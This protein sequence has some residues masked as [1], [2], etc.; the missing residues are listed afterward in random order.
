MIFALSLAALLALAGLSIDSLRVFIV[1]GQAQRAAE[2]AALAG[3]PYVPQ[4]P[5]DKTSA[6]DGN[7]ARDRALQAAAQNGFT[8]SSAITITPAAG[9]PATLTVTIH[10]NVALTLISL[11]DPSPAVGS[12][13]ATAEMLPPVALGDS[14]GAFGTL[15][16][17]SEAAASAG[18][19]E[20]KERGDPYSVL[21]EDGWSQASDTTH[22]DAGTD[23]YTTRL[24]TT[25]NAPQYPTGPD[26]SPG[27]PGNPDAVPAGFGGLQT[28]DNPVVTGESYLITLPPGSGEYSVWVDNPRFAYD[29]AGN[30]SRFFT[31]ESVFDKGT[32]APALYPQIAYSLFAVP[33]LYN[34]VADVPLAAIWPS[35]TSVPDTSPDSPLSAAQIYRDP[36]VDLAHD[37]PSPQVWS[38]E[39]AC[40]DAP[41]IGNWVQLPAPTSL[42]ATATAPAY[43]RLTVSSTIG[44]NA[45]YGEQEYAVKICQSPA[46]PDDPCSTGGASLAAW[47]A[48]TVHLHST[49]SSASFPLANIPAAYAGRSV[50]FRLFNAGIGAGNVTLAILPPASGGSVT[51][52]AY[53]RLATSGSTTVIQ[54]SINGDDLYHGK[55]IDLTLTLLPDYTGGEWQLRWTSDTAPPD[56]TMTISATLEGA[57]I[58]LIA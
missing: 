2:A 13:S 42:T 46:K 5:D 39:G 3:V 50:T 24:G 34:R 21:C 10:I 28:G 47:N 40:V 19:N 33:E 7:D 53:L 52:P 18:P 56:A 36:P 38:V 37:C 11:V 31:S 32:D 57:A 45:G 6:P 20:L 49:T 30:H 26:C 41:D 4:Y 35:S 16:G 14:S 51:Y 23:I 58:S 8:D 29:A 27:T 44:D 54:T 9:P 17:A 25:T 1:F 12:A 48:E 43:Y 55:W 15:S 22:A